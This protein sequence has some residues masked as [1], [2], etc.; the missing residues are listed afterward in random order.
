MHCDMGCLTFLLNAYVD[1]V[2]ICLC[3]SSQLVIRRIS[4]LMD[5]YCLGGLFSNFCYNE[6]NLGKSIAGLF[7]SSQ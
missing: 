5:I 3:V 4:L 2:R 7:L 1:Y 6:T